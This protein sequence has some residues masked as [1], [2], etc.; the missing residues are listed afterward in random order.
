MRT[1]SFRLGIVTLAVALLVNVN[2]ISAQTNP[3]IVIQDKAILPQGIAYNAAS[4][5][6]LVG[7]VAKG[8]IYEVDP[9]GSSKVFVEDAALVA[10]TAIFVD[11]PN[12]RLLAVSSSLAKTISNGMGNGAPGQGNGQPPAGF[13]TPDP[14]QMAGGAFPSLDPNN[15]PAGLQMPDFTLKLLAFDLT[16]R[17]KL[18]EVDLTNVAPQGPRFGN[19]IAVDKDGI[20]YVTDSLAGAIYRIDKNDQA[21]YLSDPKFGAQQPQP[22]GQMGQLPGQGNPNSPAGFGAMGAGGLTGIVYNQDGYLV[23]AESG[24]GSLYKIAL[25]NPSNI[26]TISL[27][28]PLKGVTGLALQPDGKLIVTV[29]NEGKLYALTSGDNWQ[30]ATIVNTVDAVVNISS[31]AIYGSTIYVLQSDLVTSQQGSNAGA[32]ILQFPLQ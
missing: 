8:G 10:T 15:L 25:D 16:S 11:I 2:S 13:P 30:S 21:Q 9:D 20:I 17:A 7:S 1:R 22:S 29:S 4:N 18:L 24:S 14:T 28:Q 3:S 26:Q 31:T 23:V 12:N 27:A 32:S 19:A 5:I 6:I